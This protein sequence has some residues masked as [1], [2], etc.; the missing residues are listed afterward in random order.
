ME[1]ERLFSL[2]RVVPEVPIALFSLGAGGG[3]S[4]CWTSNP[5]SPGC[6]VS[7]GA[8]SNISA[9]LLQHVLLLRRSTRSYEKVY[10]NRIVG[11]LAVLGSLG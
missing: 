8:A 11:C 3:G 7:C 4:V 9:C 5:G 10:H 1:G 2:V 6:S